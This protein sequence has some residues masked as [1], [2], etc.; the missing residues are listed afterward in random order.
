[1]ILNI[2]LHA[3]PFFVIFLLS[4][5]LTAHQAITK[6]CE[7]DLA[8]KFMFK[9]KLKTIWSHESTFLVCGS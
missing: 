7:I 5:W 3:E 6:S 1:M 8:S 2:N 9:V 4:G